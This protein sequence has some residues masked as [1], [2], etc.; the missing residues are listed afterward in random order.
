[1]KKT[2]ADIARDMRLL[3][4]DEGQAA[5]L[6]KRGLYIDL[7]Q[8]LRCDERLWMLVLQREDVPPSPVEINTCR[9]AFRVP[10]DASELSTCRL[11]SICWLEPLRLAAPA[12]PQ[13]IQEALLV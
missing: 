8:R 13:L 7:Y 10:A 11:T 12:E 6:L 3:A 5:V 2:L 9:I 1:M 4:I